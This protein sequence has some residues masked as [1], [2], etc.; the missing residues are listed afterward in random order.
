MVRFFELQVRLGNLTADK[1]PEKWRA[2]V[3]AALEETA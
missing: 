1:V 3:Q 2:A